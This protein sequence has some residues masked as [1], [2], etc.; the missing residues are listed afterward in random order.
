MRAQNRQHLFER[1]KVTIYSRA[2]IQHKIRSSI[3]AANSRGKFAIYLRG[4][5]QR[6]FAIRPVWVR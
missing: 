5:F 3:C 4:K 1:K 6:K 2:K